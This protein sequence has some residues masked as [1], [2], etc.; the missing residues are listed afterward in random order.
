MPLPH[1]S[2]LRKYGGFLGVG[3]RESRGLGEVSE[4]I[5]FNVL[6]LHCIVHLLFFSFFLGL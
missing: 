3:S 6:A 2:A 5:S 1:L 4:R